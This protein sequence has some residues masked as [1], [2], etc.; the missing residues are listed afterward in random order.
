MPTA[1]VPSTIVPLPTTAPPS[2]VLEV[3]YSYVKRLQTYSL[4]FLNMLYVCTLKDEL[5]MM[6]GNITLLN[7]F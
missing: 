6:H 5:E 7:T 1:V 2:T 4:A 3:S